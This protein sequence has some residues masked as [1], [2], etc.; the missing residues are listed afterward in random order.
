MRANTFPRRH[1]PDPGTSWRAR[2]GAI[3]A[4]LPLGK[5]P[6][7]PAG[8]LKSHQDFLSNGKERRTRQTVRL[9]LRDLSDEVGEEL[10]TGSLRPVLGFATAADKQPP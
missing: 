9:E 1:H 3:P 4:E 2:L 5:R 8:E 7:G 6:L 10:S